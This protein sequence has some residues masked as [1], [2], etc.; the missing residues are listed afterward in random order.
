MN[1][2]LLRFIAVGLF[3]TALSFSIFNVLFFITNLSPSLAN[4]ISLSI[5]LCVSFVLNIKYVFQPT[6]INKIHTTFMLFVGSTLFSQL[7]VQQLTFIL[8][9]NILAN[10]INTIYSYLPSG[11]LADTFT[12][13]FVLVNLSKALST[14]L[15]A[16]TTYYL[17]KSVV[18]KVNNTSYVS[19]ADKR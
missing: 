17:Y 12:E 11:L 7:V 6:E 5:T 3:N 8:F 9:L 15:S 16:L 13:E 19:N 1:N 18:F 2:R 10:P 14:I 4:F